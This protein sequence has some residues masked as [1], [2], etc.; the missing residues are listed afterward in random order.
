MRQSETQTVLDEIAGFDGRTFT[1]QALASWHSVLQSYRLADAL[2]AV[3]E[4]YSTNTTRIMPAE[5]RSRC[6]H[7]A[8]IRANAERRALPPPTAPVLTDVGRRARA[9]VLAQIRSVAGRMDREMA[10]P[11]R[12]DTTS[13]TSPDSGITAEVRDQW[14]A[15]LAAAS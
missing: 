4:H 15:R 14:A 8:D 2:Q 10:R 3:R 11:M 6:I 12:A 13:P 9:E 5:V 1:D 7:L